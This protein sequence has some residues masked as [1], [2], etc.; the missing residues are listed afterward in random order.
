MVDNE[1]KVLDHGYLKLVETWGSEERIIEAARMSTGKG[2]LGWGPL[3]CSKCNGNGTDIYIDM[4]PKFPN[5]GRLC[6]T[7]QGSG[8]IPG[9]E[10]LLR[11]L[12]ENKHHTPFEMAGLTVEVQA[13]IMVFRQW[14][15]HR[16]QS[17]NE[18]SARYGPLP[19]MDYLPTLERLEAETTDNR[20]AQGTAAFDGEAAGKW[21]AALD[22]Y[23]NYGEQ[24]MQQALAAG[25]PKELARLSNTVGR[26]SK[27]RCSANLR[28]WFHFLGLRMDSHAQYEIRQYANAVGDL[29]AALFPR[30]WA[31]FTEG[32]V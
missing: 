5:A 12:W 14:F 11:Y 21:L 15:T 9:D 28:N 25:V 22:G 13:P 1:I 6:N 4:G 31:M 18:H 16:T 27:M 30:T 3:V 19:A 20:Q 17:R 7:C 2:F 29:V 23:Y 32:R 24:L 8:K 26:Y 10:K